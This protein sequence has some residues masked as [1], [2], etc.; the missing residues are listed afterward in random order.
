M[1]KSLLD[2][3]QSDEREQDDIALAKGGMNLK[4]A[5]LKVLQFFPSLSSIMKRT[6]VVDKGGSTSGGVAATNGDSVMFNASRMANYC[7]SKQ[8]GIYAHE[9]KHI[10]RGDTNKDWS[11]EFN[12]GTDAVI[13]EEV[14]ASGLKLDGCIDIPNAREYGAEKIRDILVKIRAFIRKDAQKAE[15]DSAEGKQQGY[16]RKEEHFTEE[17]LNDAIFGEH[18]MWYRAMDYLAFKEKQVKEKLWAIPAKLKGLFTPDP[19]KQDDF[20][21]GLVPAF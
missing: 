5:K 9:L 16:K 8:A 15:M 3:V 17:N 1:K 6:K 18:S 11:Q 7:E 2:Q 4:A 12:E 13:N 19:E 21:G 20:G 14:R 10:E